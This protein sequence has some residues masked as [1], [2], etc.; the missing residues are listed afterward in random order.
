M[1]PIELQ[2]VADAAVPRDRPGAWTHA[3][4]DL[5]ATICSPR[6]PDCPSCPARTWCAYAN[7]SAPA[8]QPRRGAAQ[9]PFPATT[10]W[11]RGQIVDR[12]RA[13]NHEDWVAIQ[14]PIGSHD[15]AAVDAALR[16]LARE[17]LVELRASDGG[18]EP[19]RPKTRLARLALV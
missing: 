1:S 10:R 13:A 18:T 7:G 4:M 3:L 17:G 2:R 5:G 9:P 11:L 15:V 16:A 8:T 12:L 6:Q 14:A 19:R